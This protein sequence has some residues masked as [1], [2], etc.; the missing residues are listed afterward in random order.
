MP[1]WANARFWILGGSEGI[2]AVNGDA[3]H[4][5]GGSNPPAQSKFLTITKSIRGYK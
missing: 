4:M 3:D 2:A 5:S 1:S